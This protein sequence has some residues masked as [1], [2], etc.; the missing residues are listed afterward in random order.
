[1]V[2][3][4]GH[5]HG[6]GQ[7]QQLDL[8]MESSIDDVNVSIDP[9][10]FY[11]NGKAIEVFQVFPRQ[12]QAFQYFDTLNGIPEVKVQ[13]S[14]FFARKDNIGNFLRPSRL[15]IPRSFAVPLDSLI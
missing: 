6:R 14:L 7:G 15:A 8:A 3:K 10:L 5:G 12:E 4:L 13:P 1:M 11:S 2:H 9:H